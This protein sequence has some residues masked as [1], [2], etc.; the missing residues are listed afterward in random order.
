M[1]MVSKVQKVTHEY[2]RT[3]LNHLNRNLLLI[4]VIASGLCALFFNCLSTQRQKRSE[5][6]GKF[7]EADVTCQCEFVKGSFIHQ[8]KK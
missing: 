7:L 5:R 8:W 4:C 3:C 2:N 6:K 1:E